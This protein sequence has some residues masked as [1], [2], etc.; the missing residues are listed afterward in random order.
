MAAVVLKMTEKT[1][2]TGGHSQERRT[3]S[4]PTAKTRGLMNAT[5]KQDADT[6]A[7]Q[8]LHVSDARSYHAVKGQKKQFRT[9]RL[10]GRAVKEWTSYIGPKVSAKPVQRSGSVGTEYL[11]GRTESTSS[12][13]KTKDTVSQCTKPVKNCYTFTKLPWG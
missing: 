6:D 8:L 3:T 10:R 12:G 5:T 4:C 2:T 9:S 13:L 7:K 1:A 11:P